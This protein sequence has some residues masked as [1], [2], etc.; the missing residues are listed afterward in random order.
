[1]SG[2]LTGS[3]AILANDENNEF[4]ISAKKYEKSSSFNGRNVYYCMP[5]KS[6]YIV[7]YNIKWV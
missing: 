1:M 2:F 7:S 6:F 4:E 5:M 3:T